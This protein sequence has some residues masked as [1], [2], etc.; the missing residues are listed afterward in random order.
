MG[1]APLVASAAQT[2]NPVRQALRFRNRHL[3]DDGC[4]VPDDRS[5]AR[6]LDDEKS[7]GQRG[8][9]GKTVV[10]MTTVHFI[11]VDLALLIHGQHHYVGTRCSLD[12]RDMSVPL[13]IC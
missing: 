9:H 5:G 6:L 10:N 7:G 4:C 11:F 2:R 3:L 13:S 8:K 1:S 12:G